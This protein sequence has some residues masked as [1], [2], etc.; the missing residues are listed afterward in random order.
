M[1]P[2]TKT[3][4]T[5]RDLL[6]YM[7]LFRDDEPQEAQDAFNEFYRRYCHFLTFIVARNCPK[8]SAYYD[9]S[10]IKATVHN[11]FYRVY[12][13][14]ETFISD[15]KKDKVIVERQVKAWLSI[16]A[17][18]ELRQLLKATIPYLKNY[19]LKDDFTSST[20]LESPV[21]LQEDEPVSIKRE[22]IDKALGCLPEREKE[23]LL[24]YF[25]FEDGKKQL[26]KEELER[27]AVLYDTT[28][29]NLRQIKLRALKKVK[30]YI[31][32]NSDYEIE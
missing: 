1:L 21:Y 10:L 17:K 24:T 20:L 26:P 6:A 12:F 13:R 11:T 7:A 31:K 25:R 30:D 8:N 3:N 4:E 15:E 22:L 14:A 9:E 23:V 16:I 32:A 29:D 19:D 27:L 5:S 18:N 2:T 28:S